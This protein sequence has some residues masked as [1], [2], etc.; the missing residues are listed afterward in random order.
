MSSI[1]YPSGARI[2]NPITARRAVYVERVA[3]ENWWLRSGARKRRRFAAFMLVLEVVLAAWAV[4]DPHGFFSNGPAT[5]AWP[6]LGPL[7]TVF[8]IVQ[9]IRAQRDLRAEA[10]ALE[11]DGRARLGL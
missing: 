1:R 6:V 10:E 11:R 2:K 5:W 9:L 4:S 8:L 3:K 7:T